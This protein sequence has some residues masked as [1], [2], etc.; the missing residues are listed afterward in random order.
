MSNLKIAVLVGWISRP[1]LIIT[2]LVNSRLLIELVGIDGLAAQSILLS[3]STWLALLNLGIPQAVQNM[4]SKYRAESLDFEM[5]KQT[6]SSAVLLLFLI[7]LPF[8]MGFGVVIKYFVLN[9][10]PDVAL[11]TVVV[12]CV[13][14]FIAGLSP[15][16]NHILYAEQRAYW[17][18][19]YSSINAICVT[20]ILITFR[21]LKIQ[22]VNLVL[23]AF[24][25][26]NILVA[27]LGILQTNAFRIWSLDRQILID[28]WQNCRGFA[29]FAF[30]ASGV[31]GIDY[32]IMSRILSSKDIAMY[33]ICQRVFMGIFSVYGIILTSSWSGI[34]EML[35]AKQWEMARKKIRSLLFLGSGIVVIIS[36]IVIPF[37]S[38]IVDII[39]NGNIAEVPIM[40]TVLFL[41]YLLLRIWTDTF[42]IALLSF[43]KTKVLNRSMLFHATISIVFQFLFGSK[44]GANG[45]L[46]GLIISYLLTAVWMFPRAFYKALCV[47]NNGHPSHGAH[48]ELGKI[49]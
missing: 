2:T 35:F 4:I 23:Y 43:N 3:L 49:L 47:N 9:N 39:S 46:L 29:F 32:L 40:F 26:A 34:S 19:L 21:S 28:I 33:N 24:V 31:I 8:V 37:M 38:M 48:S 27:V 7:F 15:L 13:G 44:F 41:V 42:S 5:L 17:P 25:I 6:A 22:N 45:I 36:G 10:Y 12:F 20:S 1:L 11:S 30:L 14:L 18:N 16:F